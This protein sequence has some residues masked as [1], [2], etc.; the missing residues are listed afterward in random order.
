MLLFFFP[1]FVA[2]VIAALLPVQQYPPFGRRILAALN[3][4]FVGCFVALSFRPPSYGEW[5]M[6]DGSPYFRMTALLL[7]ISLLLV[8]WKSFHRGKLLC[9]PFVLALLFSPATLGDQTNLPVVKTDTLA[10]DPRNTRLRESKEG[11]LH[12]LAGFLQE[13]GEASGRVVGTHAFA[14]LRQLEKQ[15]VPRSVCKF[16]TRHD[17]C[18]QIGDQALTTPLL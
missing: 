5:G 3:V 14:D 15:F 2:N 13:A 18:G 7:L 10:A 9:L 17:D 8:V 11:N 4:M 16:Q 12:Y 1:L 6:G